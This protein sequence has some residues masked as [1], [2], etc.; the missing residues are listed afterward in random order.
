MAKTLSTIRTQVRSFLDESGSG[1][2]SNTELDVLINAYYHKVYTAAVTVFEDYN[3]TT[4]TFNTVADQQEYTSADS[5]PTDIFKLRRVEINYDVS[6]AS[7]APS[8]AIPITSIDSVRRDLGLTGLGAT[9]K[10]GSL[11]HYYFLGHGSGAKLGFIPIP[12]KA[13]TNAVRVWYVKMLSDLSTDASTID[14]PYP[15]QY[16]ILIAWG[17]AGDAWR[18]GNQESAEADKFERKFMEGLALM[19]SELEDKTAE[20]TKY[21][22]DTTGYEFF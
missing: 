9:L 3:I 18:F 1:D 17:A 6:N 22:T 13:G 11:A 10:A 8:R 21:I 7:S 5:L 12:D 19:Q 4:S 2:W 15:D 14:I 16:W 20:E